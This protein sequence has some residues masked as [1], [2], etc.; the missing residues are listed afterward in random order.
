MKFFILFLLTFFS[1]F[2]YDARPACYKEL[3]RNFFTYQNTTSAM[4]SYLVP[5]GQWGPTFQFLQKRQAEAEGIIK[6]KAELRSPNP[7]ENPFQPD[8]ARELL[9]ET[10]AEIF[11]RALLETGFFDYVSI[12]GIFQTIWINETPRI[13]ACLGKKH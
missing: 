7:L 6:K 2:S 1:L 13:N 3:E 5:Q 4:A 11:T 10:M 12:R 9:Q 8:V